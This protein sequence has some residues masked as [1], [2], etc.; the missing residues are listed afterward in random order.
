MTISIEKL[1]DMVLAKQED[2]TLNLTLKFSQEVQVP[3]YSSMNIMF[4]ELRDIEE[5]MRQIAVQAS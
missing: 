4:G 3:F 5:Q 1:I 2:V